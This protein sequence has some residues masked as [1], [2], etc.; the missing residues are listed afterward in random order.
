MPDE[1]IEL[2]HEITLKSII[3]NFTDISG[4]L[5]THT[6]TQTFVEWK[7]FTHCYMQCRAIIDYVAN[8]IFVYVSVC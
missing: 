7:Y 3:T 2:F 1:E 8:K 5:G 4:I 6:H